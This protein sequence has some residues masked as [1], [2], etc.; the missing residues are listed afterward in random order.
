[1]KICFVKG[2]VFFYIYKHGLR[3]LYRMMCLH[4]VMV[5]KW[6]IDQKLTEE[7]GHSDNIS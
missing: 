5:N 6:D 4:S 7:F 3:F 1:M 2:D